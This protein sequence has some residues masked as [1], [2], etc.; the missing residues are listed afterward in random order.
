MS[1]SKYFCGKSPLKKTYE[2]TKPMVNKQG[3]EKMGPIYKKGCKKY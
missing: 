2:S 3:V 1:Y